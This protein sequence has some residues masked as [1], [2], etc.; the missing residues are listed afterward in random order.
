MLPGAKP[1]IGGF[2]FRVGIRSSR[3]Y[4]VLGNCRSRGLC[5]GFE[6]F[7][8]L[9]FERGIGYS[10]GEFGRNN[11]LRIVFSQFSAPRI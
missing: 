7:N 1:D 6:Y 8:S 10:C 2:G 9:R 5:K 11:W 4:K 3:G